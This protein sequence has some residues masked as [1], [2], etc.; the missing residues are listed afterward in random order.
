MSQSAPF[1][2]LTSDSRVARLATLDET[3]YPHLVPVCYATDGRAYYSALDAKPKRVPPERL[4]RVRNIR[5][6]PRVALLFDHY[7]EDWRQLRYVMVQGQAELISQGPEWE[8]A[9]GLLTAKYPQYATL[10]LGE[11]GLMIKITPERVVAWG[12]SP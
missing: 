8:A 1:A 4:R 12:A 2:A 10:A 6:N 5:A 11:R 3:G 7:E 9:R